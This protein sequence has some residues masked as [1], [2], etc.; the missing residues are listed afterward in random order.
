M[1]K[2]M[3]HLAEGMAWHSIVDQEKTGVDGVWLA[4]VDPGSMNAGSI[5]VCS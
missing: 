1:S 4:I 2:I 3:V 5:I